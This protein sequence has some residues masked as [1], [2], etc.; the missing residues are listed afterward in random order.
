[1]VSSAP[2]GSPEFGVG[3]QAMS[4]VGAERK[5]ALTATPEAGTT[6]K[7]FSNGIVRTEVMAQVEVLPDWLKEARN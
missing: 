2:D 1:M 7:T 4:A 6:P 5:R 3:M